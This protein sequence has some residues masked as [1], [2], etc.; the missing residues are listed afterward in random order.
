MLDYRI[1][2]LERMVA[3]LLRVGTVEAVD[4]SRAV[5]TVRIGEIVTDWLPWFSRR[6]GKDREWWTPEPGE[7]VMLLSPYGDTTQGHILPGLYQAAHPA[8][9]DSSDI[10]RQTFQDGAVIEYDRASHVLKA[11]VP[12]QA[13]VLADKTIFGTAGQHIELTAPT[14]TLNGFTQINGALTQGGGSNGGN[15]RLNGTLHTVKD[16]TTDAD[17]VANVSLNNH[18]HTCPHGSDTSTPK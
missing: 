9:A 1:A 13:E 11:Y 6:A 5:A 12:G 17:V 4:A 18:T 3:N 15:A 10:F 7:Q 8:P 14:I 2:E 16:I